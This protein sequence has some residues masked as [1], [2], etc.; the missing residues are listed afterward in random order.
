MTEDTLR[1]IKTRQAGD[2][3][4]I[5]FDL[6]ERGKPFTIPSGAYMWLNMWKR[7]ADDTAG[8]QVIARRAVTAVAGEKKV[9][10]VPHIADVVAGKYIVQVYGTV[11]GTSPER[12]I[13]CDLLKWDIL[14]NGGE[15]DFTHP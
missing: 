10:Y 3:T 11:P 2:T 4:P 12:Q 1:S 15:L 13:V 6:T 8:G 5:Q 9:T 7:N 14:A